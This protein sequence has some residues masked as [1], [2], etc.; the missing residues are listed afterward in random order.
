[1]KNKIIVCIVLLSIVVLA[2]AISCNQGDLQAEYDTLLTQ[3]DTLLTQYEEVNEQLVELQESLSEAQTLQTQYD[4]LMVQYDE[5]AD[6]NDTNLD[7]I[8]SLESQIEELDNEIDGLT[9]EIEAKINE[10]ANLVAD[11]DELKAQYDAMVGSTLE[12]NEEN[13]EQAL[14]D[15]INQERISHDLNALEVG[16]NLVSYSEINSQRMSISKEGEYYTDYWVP[17]QRIFIATGYSSLDRI[18]NAAM[19]IWKSHALSYEANIL[20]EDALYG[21]VSVVKSGEVYYI[22]FMGSNFP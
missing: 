21:A 3:Y 20:D 7:E 11:Y 16:H 1:M 19:T 17:F 22:T 9:D 13:I 10:I 18:A 8:A 14:F 6:Q 12:I 5:L 2:G 15:L 4:D